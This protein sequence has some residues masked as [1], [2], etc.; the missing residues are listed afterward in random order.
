MNRLAVVLSFALLTAACTFKDVKPTLMPTANEAKRPTVTTIVVGDIVAAD[1]LW[2]TYRLHVSRGITEW[3]GRNA[4]S[5]KVLTA[6]PATPSEDTVVL[7]GRITE[8]DK[9]NS[10]LR[11]FIG[12]GAGQAKMK[13]DF[14][15]RRLDGVLLAKFSARESYLGGAGIGGAG[16]LDL[17]DLARRFGE[18]VAESALKW[19]RGESME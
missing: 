3:Y 9:G 10:A 18:T 12:M 15:I 14:E 13:G 2:E 19:S 16:I 4:S 11:L 7:V 17:E 8:V 6:K 1:P 5:L